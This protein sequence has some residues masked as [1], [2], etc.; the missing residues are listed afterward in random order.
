MDSLSVNV[1]SVSKSLW[2][3]SSFWPVTGRGRGKFY[4]NL[5][6]ETPRRTQLIAVEAEVRLTLV[7]W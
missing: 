1:L 6:Y 7:L 5:N 2:P 3:A 4:V